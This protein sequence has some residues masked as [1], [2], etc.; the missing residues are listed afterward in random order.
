L[1][2][3]LPPD[4]QNTA[5]RAYREQNKAFFIDE[6][7]IFLKNASIR[8]YIVEGLKTWGKQNAALVLST[9]RS[10]IPGRPITRDSTPIGSDSSSHRD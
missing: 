10:M 3:E 8:S 5:P 1:I 6:A 2:H 9:N 7:W 4:S